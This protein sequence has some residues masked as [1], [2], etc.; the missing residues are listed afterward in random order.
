[1]YSILNGI[2]DAK[3]VTLSDASHRSGEEICGQWG[4]NIGL[5]LSIISVA[6]RV[7]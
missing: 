3:L 7:F 6:E 2:S 4:R 1:M 5:L